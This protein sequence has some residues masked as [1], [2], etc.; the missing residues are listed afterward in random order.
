MFKKSVLINFSHRKKT[1]V[2]MDGPLCS[3]LSAAIIP[4]RLVE[5]TSNNRSGYAEILRNGRWAKVCDNSWGNNEMAV[6]CRQLG[7]PAPNWYWKDTDLVYDYRLG[8]GYSLSAS[9]YLRSISCLGSENNILDCPM[10]ESFSC[11]S[12]QPVSPSGPHSGSWTECL[13]E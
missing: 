8:A 1:S 7:Y 4:V 9:T 2:I 10:R 11:N 5:G 6:V 12:R 3:S 13:G